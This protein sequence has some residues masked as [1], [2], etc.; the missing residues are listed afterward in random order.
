MRWKIIA[1]SGYSPRPQRGRVLVIVN[2]KMLHASLL[3]LII[4]GIASV[5]AQNPTFHI[6]SDASSTRKCLTVKKSLAVEML[7]C[8]IAQDDNWWKLNFLEMTVSAPSH[9]DG[10]LNRDGRKSD[11]E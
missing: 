2:L 9:N 5:G 6:V 10:R 11:S 4:T 7:V 8:L 3:S 1:L